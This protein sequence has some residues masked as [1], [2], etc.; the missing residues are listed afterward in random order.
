MDLET[1]GH[2]R[3]F[4]AVQALLLAQLLMLESFPVE[5]SQK[6]MRFSLRRGID[7]T[8][9]KKHPNN[10]CGIFRHFINYRSVP[11]AAS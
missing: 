3:H 7:N 6:R 2:R 9:I 11:L 10:L 8:L 1:P 5:T 4:A